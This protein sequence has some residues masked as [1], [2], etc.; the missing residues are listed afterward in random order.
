MKHILFCT[1]GKVLNT[2]QSSRSQASVNCEIF[3]FAHLRNINVW[4]SSENLCNSAFA[5]NVEHQIWPWCTI[6]KGNL[7]SY[8]TANKSQK[9]SIITLT[10]PYLCWFFSSTSRFS[11]AF[12]ADLI[13]FHVGTQDSI[14]C[15]Y[16]RSYFSV[17]VSRCFFPGCSRFQWRQPWPTFRFIP[18]YDKADFAPLLPDNSAK[19]PQ[20]MI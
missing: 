7:K 2:R 16:C 12:L 5:H 8:N 9:K 14:L 19:V 17:I 18:S 4:A 15:E 13:C 1:K 3:L 11:T 20:N 6:G 10:F